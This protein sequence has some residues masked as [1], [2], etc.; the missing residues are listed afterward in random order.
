MV[1]KTWISLF[2]LTKSFLILTLECVALT[3][4]SIMTRFKVIIT[5]RRVLGDMSW[6][7]MK[8]GLS[9]RCCTSVICCYIWRVTSILAQPPSHVRRVPYRY[10]RGKPL[11]C[12]WLYWRR[13][14]CKLTLDP[15][16]RGY[17][18]VGLIGRLDPNLPIRIQSSSVELRARSKLDVGSWSRKRNKHQGHLSKIK[19]DEG[20]RRKVEVRLENLSERILFHICT[21]TRKY[22]RSHG[23]DY[24]S[25]CI[26]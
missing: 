5:S 21:H 24:C 25:C 14:Y 1:V 20:N 2:K 3:P 22:R 18:N 17:S 23:N 15:S 12:I 16:T 6:G 11:H 8:A 13:A 4:L 10:I 26:G 19:A 7:S 9:N